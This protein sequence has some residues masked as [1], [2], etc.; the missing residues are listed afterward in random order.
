M[1]PSP[2]RS[3]R[4]EHRLRVLVF[5]TVFPNAAQPLLGTFVLE[6]IRHL[7]DFAEIRVVAPV[8]WYRGFNRLRSR[9]ETTAG[10]AVVH[11]RWWLFPRIFKALDGLF[12]FASAFRDVARL[13]RAFDF[14]LIDA[15]F[16]YPD[17]FAAILLGKW[18][19]KPVCIT[20]RGTIIP[21]SADPL[22]KRLCDWAIR[23]AERVIAVA[24]NLADRARQGGVPDQRIEII[25]NG[26]DAER[27]AIVER[28]LARARLD[29]R[30]TGRL[31]VSVGHLSPRKGFQRIIRALPR[32]IAGCP[33]ARLAIVGGKGGEADNSAELR[34]LAQELGLADRVLFVGP[35]TPDRVALWLGAADAFVLASDF[36]GCPNVVLEAMACGRPVIAT[37]V[38][39]VERMVPDFAGILLDD[40]ED[41]L[42][43]ADA[44]LVALARRWDAQRI[45]KHVAAQ[46]WDDVA[47]RVAAQ[48]QLAKQAFDATTAGKPNASPA[49]PLTAL[50]SP[51]A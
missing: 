27:F 36:E 17:G 35:E 7:T 51:E 9:S 2:D 38:G 14:D 10:L 32:V 30:T 40:P 37:K 25:A 31:L 16:A 4:A 29:L 3:T 19:A 1:Q 13:R 23:R 24:Q 15:H 47:R 41:S 48:W 12:L 6:R 11:P 42:A 39:H 18:F 5:T 8:S 26:V 49:S 28:D 44:A 50:R 22:R 34:A 20:L 21:L 46:S 45:R 43:L 33:D